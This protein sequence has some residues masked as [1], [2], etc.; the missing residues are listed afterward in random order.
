MRKRTKKTTSELVSSTVVAKR[1]GVKF[2]AQ[3]SETKDKFDL[4]WSKIVA[5]VKQSES[6]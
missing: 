2:D 5:K 6:R 1:K 4:M 3:V